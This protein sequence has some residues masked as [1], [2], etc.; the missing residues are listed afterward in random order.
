MGKIGILF[1]VVKYD[2]CDIVQSIKNVKTSHFKLWDAYRKSIRIS[3]Q[4]YATHNEKR[5]V[6]Y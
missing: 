3:R 4:S 1:E 6:L 5:L 2:L